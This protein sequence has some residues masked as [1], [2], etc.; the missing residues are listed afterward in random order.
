MEVLQDLSFIEL[1][2]LI[3][4]YGEKS[5]RATQ[6]YT[7]LHSGLKISEI[8]T[9]SKA[10]KEK[11]L[12]SYVDSPVEIVKKLVSKDGTEKFLFK[13]Y[14]GNI[15]EGVYMK[16]RYGNT[17]CLST[18]VGCRMGCTFCASGIGG[19]VRNLTAGE[20]LATIAVVNR[21]GG[22]TILK[23][24]VTNIVLMGSGEP[25]D[26]YDNVIKFL[27]LVSS[28]NGLNVSLRNISLSTCGIVPKMI[29]LAEENLPVN[30]TV[31]LHE[32]FNDRRMELMPISKVYS[33]DEILK[34]CDYYFEKTGRRFIFEY[35]LV[36]GK[37]DD[38]ESANELIRL[39]KHRPCHVNIIR[40]NEVKENNLKATTEKQAYAFCTL[41][42]K[43]GLSATVRR[44]NGADIEGACGQLRRSYYKGD[45]L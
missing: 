20:M 24:A 17:Q 40:L 19:L 23:R 22:G 25:L 37:N 9:I 44:L 10:L 36:K 38:I 21:E 43:G 7:A 11:L 5:F 34:A 28:D 1:K 30:L 8:T 2:N 3:E 35:S 39:L 45:I 18:Q 42:E 29:K 13:L 16:N 15:I 31:S 4:S 27:K 12:S 6:I 41:L 26:N 33:V 14:D 32:P